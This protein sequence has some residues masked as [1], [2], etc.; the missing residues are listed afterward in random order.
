[1][2]EKEVDIMAEI[3]KAFG[4]EAKKGFRKAFPKKKKKQ[5]KKRNSKK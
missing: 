1:L 5:P 4:D 3:F 2:E